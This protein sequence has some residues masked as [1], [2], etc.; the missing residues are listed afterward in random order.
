LHGQI[1]GAPPVLVVKNRK[2]GEGVSKCIVFERDGSKESNFSCFCMSG[3]GE[4]GIE[5]RGGFST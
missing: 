1:K 2:K 3:R 5:R 4:C